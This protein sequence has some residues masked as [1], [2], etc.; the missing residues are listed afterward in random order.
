MTIEAI[1]VPDEEQHY[2][3]WTPVI[4]GALVAAA[5]TFILL[6]FGAAVG[7]GISSTS[8]TWRNASAA[9]ALLSGLYLILQAIISFGLGGY[10]AGRLRSP[11]AATGT[12][13]VESRDGLHGLTAWALTVLL[14]S[15]LV[16][17]VGTSTVNRLSPFATAATAT[18][19][20]PLLSYELDRL[21]R[22]TRR[23]ANV[24]LGSERAEAGRILMTSSSRNG[25]SGDD[26][27]Y[28]VQQVGATTGLATGEAEHRVDI[29]IAD[30]KTA[31]NKSRHNTIV[32]AFSL[33]AATLFG[34]VTAWT[35][36]CVG[37]GRRDG[38]PLP[39]WME[40]PNWLSR[41]KNVVVR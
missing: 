29:A 14:G 7:L 4:A 34:A 2:L 12:E 9:L 36:A 35:M 13:E 24:D 23:P 32:V 15:V 18:S 20:E 6:T 39:E 33:A 10:I 38:A 8:P 25:V 26:R 16:A 11:L 3:Q 21:F 5:L 30:S 37:G 19:A 22:S 27:T 41:R 17:I 1:A 28:L 40:R 31:I